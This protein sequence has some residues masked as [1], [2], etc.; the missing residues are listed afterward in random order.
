MAFP[1]DNF[2]PALSVIDDGGGSTKFYRPC[3]EQLQGLRLIINERAVACGQS[4]LAAVSTPLQLSNSTI[5][6]FQSKI[7][8]CL[9]YYLNSS[10]HSTGS[11]EGL[12]SYTVWTLPTIL[13]AASV[14]YNDGSGLKWTGIPSRN[15]WGLSPAIWPDPLSQ[16]EIPF[17]KEHVNEMLSVANLLKYLIVTPTFVYTLTQRQGLAFGGTCASRKADAI[18]AWNAASWTGS[19][20]GVYKYANTGSPGVSPNSARVVNKRAKVQ[21]DLSGVLNG[22]VQIYF[23]LGLPPIVQFAVGIRTFGQTRP[24]SSA[25]DTWGVWGTGGMVV[26]SLQTSSYITESDTIPVF[27]ASLDCLTNEKTDGW[28]AGTIV[29]GTFFPAVVLIVPD[30]T[31]TYFV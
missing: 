18:T 4:E 13:A 2:L 10:I 11:I 12:A 9:Q 25:Q 30:I 20:S 17:F 1:A 3:I 23:K 19:G 8:A 21:Y 28:M 24:T 7:E 16:H 29:S 6:S 22:T 27:P 15:S 31:W 14:G 26:G 5:R